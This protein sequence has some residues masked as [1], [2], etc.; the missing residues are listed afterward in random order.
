MF[1][2]C[3]RKLVGRFLGH[4]FFFH[5]FFKKYF[6]FNVF[7]SLGKIGAILL[8]EQEE[9]AKESFCFAFWPFE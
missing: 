8:P 9:R 5:I 6:D 2:L 4:F 3:M 7:H 1:L